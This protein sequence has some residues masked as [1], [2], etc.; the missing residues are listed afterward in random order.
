M[1][2]SR[3]V[4]RAGHF[5]NV[6]CVKLTISGSRCSL[7]VVTHVASWSQ[8]PLR[9]VRNGVGNRVVRSIPLNKFVFAFQL[10]VRD[11]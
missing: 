2:I 5:Q 6:L 4:Q 1:Q 9:D 3:L 11:L 10:F 8:V 7:S